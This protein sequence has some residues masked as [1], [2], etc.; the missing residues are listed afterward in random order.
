MRALLIQQ[1]WEKW[2]T[3]TQN[4]NMKDLKDSKKPVE[5]VVTGKHCRR[6]KR[7]DKDNCIIAVAAKEQTK[8]FVTNVRVG[9]RFTTFSLSSGD[10]LRY[11]TTPAL[12]KQLVAFDGKGKLLAP[13]T[14]RFNPPQKSETIGYQR[15][16]SKKY[17]SKCYKVKRRH[18]ARKWAQS[19]KVIKGK[20]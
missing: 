5:I 4:Q 18:K 7:R 3:K 20:L 11:S 6:G 17:H 12:R 14:Y 1:C 16:M 15:K 9:L 10:R 13:G 2:K 8:G 19:R